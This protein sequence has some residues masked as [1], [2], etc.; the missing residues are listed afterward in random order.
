MLARIEPR[1]Y[2]DRG[3][4]VAN[5]RVSH[6][7]MSQQMLEAHNN[8]TQ[9]VARIEN[10]AG[11]TRQLV[12]ADLASVWRPLARF[13]APEVVDAR[14]LRTFL[15]D[16]R[17]QV[18]VPVE[19]QVVRDAYWHT[20]RYEVRELIALDSSLSR[21]AVLTRFAEASRA[22]G[23]HQLK[24]LLPLRDQRLVR[25]YWQAVELGQAQGWHAV[26]FGMV[27]SLFSIPLRQGMIHYAHQTL[28]GFLRAGACKVALPEPENRHL[29]E[30]VTEPLR[31]AVE[32]A[33]S[34]NGSH[35]H[36]IRRKE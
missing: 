32:L 5:R 12:P 23:R 31:G 3:W 30:K 25:R 14:S 19:L 21:L 6:L 16:Y 8:V 18:L 2:S 20:A 13:Q 9:H 17:D 29:L 10:P 35:L 11:L 22:A 34:S 33:L 1:G 4:Q 28:S 15:E 24:R 7:P 36:V 26:V 27:L